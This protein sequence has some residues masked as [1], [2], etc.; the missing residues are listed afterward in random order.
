MI[1]GTDKVID[2][3]TK[4]AAI[5]RSDGTVALYT[6]T[7]TAEDEGM[8]LMHWIVQTMREGERW[9]RYG[10]VPHYRIGVPVLR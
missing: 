9:V 3:E 6:I 8:G 7:Q 2:W 10:E 5:E 4:R 1:V